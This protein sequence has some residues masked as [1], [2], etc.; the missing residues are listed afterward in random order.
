VK[1]KDNLRDLILNEHQGHFACGLVGIPVFT[2]WA[3]INREADLFCSM[4][5]NKGYP[6][7]L[8]MI[9]NGATTTWEHWNGNRSRIHNCYNGIGSWFY[10]AVG[11][12]RS[13]D[14]AAFQSLIIDPQVPKGIT[15]ANTSKETPYGSVSVSWRKENKLF[16]MEV[17]IPVGSNAKV[18]IPDYVTSY[19]MNGKVYAND[20]S[21]KMTGSGNYTFEWQ[22]NM[23]E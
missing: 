16:K 20:L 4:I 15:W 8:Y 11:G 2:E 7:Y 12:I 19:K 23:P 21:M 10:Q 22:E 6:G 14:S 9:E 13:D 3:V 18:I 5:L 1:V 17:S